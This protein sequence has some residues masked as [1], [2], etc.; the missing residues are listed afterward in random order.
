MA[1][2][3]LNLKI[4]IIVFI[5][6]EAIYIKTY[7]NYLYLECYKCSEFLSAKLKIQKNDALL[8]GS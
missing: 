8:I 5:Y 2:F 6:S 7:P 4:S 3:V 1:L